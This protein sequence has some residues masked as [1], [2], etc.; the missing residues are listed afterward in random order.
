MTGQKLDS[1][2]K[3]PKTEQNKPPQRGREKKFLGSL[4]GKL[5]SRKLRGCEIQ[6]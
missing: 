1:I 2:K 3:N 4:V 6:Q 5:S